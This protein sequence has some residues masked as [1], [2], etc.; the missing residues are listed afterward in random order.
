MILK[1]QTHP[2][3]KRIVYHELTCF[4]RTWAPTRCVFIPS[5]SNKVLVS[6]WRFLW[7][8]LS[9]SCR[10]AAACE[11]TGPLRPACHQPVW[12]GYRF[13][14]EYLSERECVRECAWMH[15]RERENSRRN[16]GE[17]KYV[18]VDVCASICPLY[19]LSA[20]ASVSACVWA[21]F[22]MLNWERERF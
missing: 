4:W 7:K 13:S 6:L 14:V 11:A 5:R 3:L 12:A 18:C 17:N 19:V 16:L 20:C 10:V 8:D 21:H 22:M 9:R 2:K 15:E 1:A